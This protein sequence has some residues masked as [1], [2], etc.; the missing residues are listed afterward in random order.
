MPYGNFFERNET[1]A[2]YLIQVNG[3]VRANI[4]LDQSLSEDE[5]K[6]TAK[7]HE[8]VARHLENKDIIKVI[9]IKNK[10]INFVHS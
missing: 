1:E 6:Q 2:K 4:M 7:E 5:V 10:L 3:K 9:F 8:N